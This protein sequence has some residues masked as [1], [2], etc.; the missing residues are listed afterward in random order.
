MDSSLG[1]ATSGPTRTITNNGGGSGTVL[2]APTF[3]ST[4]DAATT[5]FV[6]GE[7]GKWT[8]TAFAEMSNDA[9][10]KD[11]ADGQIKVY[12]AGALEDLDDPSSQMSNNGV[13]VKEKKSAVKTV[14]E[15]TPP[16]NPP[17]QFFRV[18]FGN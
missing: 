1:D 13:R 7:N 3:A 4:G 16:G 2:P 12:A 15:V 17:S 8:L 5:K 18:K 14:I 11:V 9:L 10:G 6:Q